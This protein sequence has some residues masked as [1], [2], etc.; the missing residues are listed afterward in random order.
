MTLSNSTKWLLAGATLIAS[1][2]T[3][4]AQT[5]LRAFVSSQH[6]PDVWRKAFD[7]YEAKNPNVK[8]AIETG[9][10]TSEAQAQYLNTVMTAKDTSLDV[11]ILD[12]IRPAQ[13][14][15]A[16]WTVPFNEVIGKDADGY[17]KRYLPAYAEANTVD[18][19][20][21]ALPAFADAMFL[22]YRKDLLEKHGVQPPTTWDELAAAS[23]KITGAEKDG[24]LQGLSFQGKAIEGAVCTFLLPYWS[25]GKQ[26][27]TD[28]KLSFDK[29][30]AVK[31]LKLWKDFVDQGVAKPNIA[32]VA[33][34]DTRKEFQA[35]NVVFAVNW[36][37]AWGQFQGAESAVKDK[38]GVVKL[39]A[40]QGGQPA[41][42]LG[43]W[44]WAVSAYSNNK[45]E[46]QKFVQYL[47]SPEVSKFMAINASLLPQFPEV[48]TDPD[49]TK[50]VAWFAT[51]RPVVETA[52]ARPVTPRYN[53]VSEI[54]R[55]TVNGVLAGQ[56]TP[57]QGADQMESRLR[58]VLR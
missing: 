16:G 9:G 52:K 58:R 12:V 36:S 13:Y 5:N 47:S 35:G 20:I 51:A 21:V 53:E 54:I 19:K 56:S 15:A 6:R 18:G 32:E 8:V 2:S 50:A 30:Q 7:M 10:N 37:Y 11:L 42:C 28:G 25:A 26:L 22:Y 38:V 33:T 43:G 17:M 39:P 27:V 34:D 24:N 31:A 45:S 46:A 55:T 44:E 41:S 1:V 57:E 23:K 49:V 3:A 29:A 14:A 4:F 40:V 48:Y